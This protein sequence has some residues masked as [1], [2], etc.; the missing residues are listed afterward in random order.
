MDINNLIQTLVF[1]NIKDISKM[2][3]REL[4]PIILFCL[5]FSY[6]ESILTFIQ[7]YIKWNSYKSQIVNEITSR[8]DKD[9][10]LNIDSTSSVSYILWYYRKNIEA[11]KSSNVVKEYKLR[12]GAEK[13]K[14]GLFLPDIYIPDINTTVKLDTDVYL[15][16]IHSSKS[17]KTDKDTTTNEKVI[18]LI[19]K[20]KRLDSLTLKEWLDDTKLSYL[21]WNRG[22][23][24]L[25]LY[26]SHIRDNKLDFNL[27]NLNST[28]T[29]NNLFFEQK[30]LIINRLKQYAD[31][32]RYKKLGIPHTLG[33]LF[34]GEPG[35]GKTSCI[36]AIAN[37]LQRSIITIN[38]KHVTDIKE[39]TRLFLSEAVGIWSS[40]EKSKRMYVFE[41]IDCCVDEKDNP[42]LDR[43]LQ[44]KETK[45]EDKLDK[46]ATALLKDEKSEI[47]IPPKIT[48]GEVLELL[49]GICETDDRIIIFTTNHPEK[50]D[51]AF[52]RP[53]R[54]DMSIEFKKLRRVDI[55]NLY[56][57]WFGK[58]IGE[59][60]LNKI[61][62]YSLSQAEF[63]KLCFEN[64]A[65][66]VL[67]KLVNGGV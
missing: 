23:M 5:F 66:K 55:N 59:K 14:E 53:G 58:V 10:N 48:T 57:L 27:Y 40:E 30:E 52:M 21:K 46:L 25:Y 64:N 44:K 62:D 16:F 51:K 61:K 33:F 39:L 9:G 19:L 60:A 11:I 26:L 50:I 32:E 47:K 41:E 43:N 36:K 49:D 37:H 31:I 1:M 22:D 38:L 13:D 20:S 42:F 6:K 54:I 56:K 15:E 17:I 12:I 67:E 29:F 45:E 18:T 4:F 7:P 34:Y 24:K 8:F 65:E 3:Y 2:S 35:C 63:G 28:K